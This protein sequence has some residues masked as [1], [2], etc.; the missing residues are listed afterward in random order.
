MCV[1]QHQKFILFADPEE[2]FHSSCTKL[3]HI[4]SPDKFPWNEISEVSYNNKKLVIVCVLIEN[5]IV[6]LVNREFSEGTDKVT[7]WHTSY[8][9]EA[10][11]LQASVDKENISVYPQD[12]LSVVVAKDSILKSTLKPLIA[13]PNVMDLVDAMDLTPLG[14]NL[15]EAVSVLL[16]YLPDANVTLNLCSRINSTNRNWHYC[17]S[18]SHLINLRR[19]H[20]PFDHLIGIQI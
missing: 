6:I 16:S 1:Y 8:E 9:E 19:F 3:S 5:W 15:I 7:I 2:S 17:R 20:N 10:V 12:Q 11:G 13:A 4:H 14:N 18:Q